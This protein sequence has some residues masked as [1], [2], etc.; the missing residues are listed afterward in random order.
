MDWRTILNTPDDEIPQSIEASLATY[1]TRFAQPSDYRFHPC[2]KCGARG[3]GFVWGVVDGA[4]HCQKCG[5][6]ARRDH[7]VAGTSFHNVVLQ[8]HP[9]FV[10][11][12]RPDP[13]TGF[14]FRLI[15]ERKETAS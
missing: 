8:Y 3:C 10:E 13:F 4:G 11:E 9:D 15:P 5:W 7:Y 2:L 1:F 12:G 14:P 6:P